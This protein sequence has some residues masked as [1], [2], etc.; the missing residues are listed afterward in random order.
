MCTLLQY[1]VTID[2][3]NILVLFLCG[4][5]LIKKFSLDKTFAKPC[6]MYM[7]L[8]MN[9]NFDGFTKSV[10]HSSFHQYSKNDGVV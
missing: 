8:C 1:T 9:I 4:Y 7:Y 3:D 10:I 2:L 5:L 6:Y